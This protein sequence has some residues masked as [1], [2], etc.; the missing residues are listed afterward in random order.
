[1]TD[2]ECS[3]LATLIEARIVEAEALDA[4]ASESSAVVTLDQQS[5]GRLARTDA[6]Q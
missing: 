1:M 4:A 5:V 2:A 6:M 3:E